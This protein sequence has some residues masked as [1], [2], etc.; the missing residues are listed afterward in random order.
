MSPQVTTET[1]IAAISEMG[2]QGFGGPRMPTR[3][4]LW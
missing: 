3:G 1:H 4:T 2:A